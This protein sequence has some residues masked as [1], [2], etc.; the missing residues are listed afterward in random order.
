MFAECARPT[1][2]TEPASGQPDASP[3]LDAARDLVKDTP[4]GRALKEKLEAFDK[5]DDAAKEKAGPDIRKDIADIVAR[6]VTEEHQRRELLNALSNFRN[7]QILAVSEPSEGQ[8]QHQ[9]VAQLVDVV[10]DVLAE[11]GK[12]TLIEALLPGATSSSRRLTSWTAS[13]PR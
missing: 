1:D 9:L 12:E 11:L 5:L 4:E 8:E 2:V 10:E 13:S 7:D 6:A 3:L